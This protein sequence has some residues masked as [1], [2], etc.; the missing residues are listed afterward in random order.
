MASNLSV[1]LARKKHD[2]V[3]VD[4]DK[5]GTCAN[6]ANDRESFNTS[7]VI[8]IVQ[9]YD[10]VKSTLKDLSSRYDYVIA[11]VAGHDS[12]EMRTAL[13]VA[14]LVLIPTQCSQPDLDTLE[15]MEEII[16]KARDYNEGMKVYSV[17][18]RTPTNPVIKELDDAREFMK[19]SGLETLQTVIH[20]RKAY[21]DAIK[22]GKGVIEL[23][24][25]KASIEIE[26]LAKE[27]QL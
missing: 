16:N 5:Q 10:N 20:D 15:E 9:R 17:F 24:S 6:W 19:E 21:R 2:V 1:F 27:I 7:P 22:E 12:R 25:N 26:N 23:S 8:N 3:L 4:C 14:D 13:L 11:D 18:S